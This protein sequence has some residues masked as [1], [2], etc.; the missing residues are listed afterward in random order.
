MYVLYREADYRNQELNF[1]IAQIMAE[2]KKC[3]FCGAEIMVTAKK[4]RY[5]GT[6]LENQT[7]VP[8]TN[9]GALQQAI[10]TEQA[11][12]KQGNKKMIYGLISI[13]GLII[14][15]IFNQ[16]YLYLTDAISI[17]FYFVGWL[18]ISYG[19][20]KFIISI[21]KNPTSATYWITISAIL[22]MLL[23]L[24]ISVFHLNDLVDMDCGLECF[25][26][27]HPLAIT[28]G[29]TVLILLMSYKSSSIS[30][31]QNSNQ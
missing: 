12:A 21:S 16:R 26:V 24:S 6:W 22:V 20:C 11:S 7:V 10:H 18:M 28:F 1:K 8:N 27:L 2:I 19:A 25:L 5:C 15:I 3:P 30:N 31:P 13:V 17:I 14:A 4:C 23:S 29:I 9:A